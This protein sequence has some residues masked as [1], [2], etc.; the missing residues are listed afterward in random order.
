M[1]R[2]CTVLVGLLLLSLAPLHGEDA[3]YV[4]P[5]GRDAN[6]GTL[7]Q[8]F[9][10]LER[11]REAVRRLRAEQIGELPIAVFLRAGTYA[12]T[13]PFVLESEDSG[14]EK[15]PVLYRAYGDEQVE[16][17]GGVRI[18]KWKAKK[19][20]NRRLWAAE[21]A[22]VKAGQW[23]FHQLWVNGERRTPARH[24]NQGY[25]A[26]AAVP[27]R[28]ANSQWSDGDDRFS[29]RPQD[30]PATNLAGAEVVVFN[31]WVESRLPIE[32]MD[33]A[34][35]TFQFGKRS[36]FRLDV[37]DPYFVEN[38]LTLL[39]QPGEWYLDRKKG[40]L[41]YYPMAG[42][43]M[44]ACRIV[45]PR[46]TQLLLF[47][48][49]PDSNR[50]VA[51]IYWQNVAFSH[52]EWYF[53]AEFKSEWPHPSAGFTVGGFPQAAVGV[54]ACIEGNGC[55][56]VRIENCAVT[57]V[58][59]YGIHWMAGCR[60]NQVSHCEIADLGAGGIKIGEQKIREAAWQTGGNTVL[61]C[62]IHDG[63]KVFNSAIGIWIGQSFDNELIHNHIHDFYYSGLSIGWTWGY[64][65]ALAR[66]NLVELNHVH[67]I[68]VLSNGDGPVLSDMAAIYTLG[69]QPGTIIRTNLFHDVAGLRYGGWG[70]YFD[71]GSTHIL[72]EKNIVYRT[73][74]GGFHQP[75]HVALQISG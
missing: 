30:L 57:H 19:V 35:S 18:E 36:V 70:I 17:S 61:D 52:T 6:P 55:R 12:L 41:Y 54:P 40:M 9:A 21:L 53:P 26:V 42:E 28:A 7:Q 58:G 46:L 4:S 67:H 56:A 34:T 39:D 5:Q 43:T 23:N 73:T 64:G 8:P 44:D 50:F 3:L 48:G 37:D 51:H 24:P 14:S 75:S 74:H 2:A 71:E 29:Y 60:D 68:G 62:H 33:K 25:L 59:T 20:N 45:A 72:A 49:Q 16:I 32:R 63:G 10:T 27:E 47:K 65:D 1:V 31:R 38:N 69:A 11:A 13:A 22:E 15:A 66:G